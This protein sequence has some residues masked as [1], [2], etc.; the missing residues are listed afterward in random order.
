[1][2]LHT[3]LPL[4]RKYRP[5]SF[6][7]IVG[8]GPITQTLSNAIQ[9]NQVAHAYLLCGPRGTGKT[10]TARIFAKSL[11]CEQGPTT[12]PCQTCDSCVSVTAGNALDVIEFDAASNNGVQDTRELIENCQ[13]SPMHGR[14]KI[15]IIDEVHM[16]SSQA[17][18]ALLKTLEEPPEGVIFIFA[19]TEAHKVLPTIISRCQRFDFSRIALPELVG[20]LTH[21]AKTEAIAIESAAIY[22]IGRHSKGGLRDALSLL[23][24]VGVLSRS[25]S[26]YT[27]TTEDI[28][29]FLGSLTEDALVTLTTALQQQQV[30]ELTQ[31]VQSLA[32]QGIEPRQLL[33]SLTEHVRN[34]FLV[35]SITQQSPLTD[36]MTASLADQLAVTPE[37][38]GRLAQQH[39]GFDISLYP[40]LLAQLGDMERTVR[41]STQPQLWL[42]IGLVNLAFQDQLA[43]ITDLK[44]RIEQLEQGD[45]LSAPQ[46]TAPPQPKAD[47]PAQ[48]APPIAAPQPTPAPTR[49]PVQAVQAPPS[50]TPSPQPAPPTHRH[51][52]SPSLDDWNR[53]VQSIP[54]MSVKAMLSQHGFLKEVAP[55]QITMG[56]KSEPILTMLKDEGKFFHLQKAVD[57]HFG[58][59]M[60]LQLILDKTGSPSAM[61]QSSPQPT[62]TSTPTSTPTKPTA[63][64]P[65]PVAPPSPPPQQP[66]H[67]QHQA[68]SQA[69]Y[70]NQP[71]PPPLHQE[72]S[73]QEVSP[74]QQPKQQPKQQPRQQPVARMQ[75][76]DGAP[77]I[78][79][80]EAKKY[81]TQL[82]QGTFIEQPT[83]TEKITTDTLH[84]TPPLEN[85]APTP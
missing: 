34:L 27:I 51:S 63:P 71:S 76:P 20:H 43:S 52:S 46:P 16:L 9:T 60:T 61:T 14:F 56:C 25:E 2:S 77:D 17:F 70:H 75:Q 31:T 85:T 82:L 67:P 23:D 72:A 12:T 41:H 80:T 37:H 59:P 78:D 15:Y 50:V 7:E 29:R 68:P 64:S 4:Y 38:I 6:A 39:A 33:Q 30:T 84:P 55:P 22:A 26:N 5:Q 69:A 1:M 18:N 83:N 28:A 48:T 54:S 8:Q 32:H 45:G 53:I 74:Q 62:P 24:Q 40:Q 66:T 19:T 58:Q 3:Y 10:S 42:E 13:F 47:P 57:A 36:A 11:N 79:L 21:V 73:S 49:T 81:T 65:M 35:A 44:Q